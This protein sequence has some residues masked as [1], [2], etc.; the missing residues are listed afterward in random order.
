MTE[1]FTASGLHIPK[2]TSEPQIPKIDVSGD[3]KCRTEFFVFGNQKT[4]VFNS[5]AVSLS[6]LR[7][8]K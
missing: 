7:K 6:A 1:R 3:A 2:E 5:T 4:G 8:K